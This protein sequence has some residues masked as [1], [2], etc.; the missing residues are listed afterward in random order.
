MEKQVQLLSMNELLNPSQAEILAEQKIAMVKAI[1]FFHQKGWAPATSSNYSFRLPGSSDFFVS[2]SGVDKGEFAEKHFMPVDAHGE[3]L[4]DPRKPSA[5][6]ALHCVVYNLFSEVHCVLHTHTVYNTILSQHLLPQGR[7][8]LSDYE[9]LKGFAGVKT[10]EVSLEIPIF[11]NTQDIPALA[12]EFSQYV[13][14]APQAPY[15][16][17][18]AGHGMY[19]WGASISEA[20]RHVE[21]MEFLLECE[22][23]KLR[24][25]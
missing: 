5:E 15:G 11:A 6:T 2:Q 13:R 9:I 12:K 20:K 18:I 4:D 25:Q 14:R 1:R 8:I 7:L 17:L 10:H 3:A 24:V 23:N 22:M 16:F 21:V 19:T